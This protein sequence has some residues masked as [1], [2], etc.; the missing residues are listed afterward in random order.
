MSQ[1]EDNK[2]Y[3]SVF[4][5]SLIT[6]FVSAGEK[7][8]LISVPSCAENDCVSSIFLVFIL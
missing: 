7:I 8:C 2:N 1:N 3:G 5:V 6:L 4:I